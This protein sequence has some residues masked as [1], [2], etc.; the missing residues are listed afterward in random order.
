MNAD[1]ELKMLPEIYLSMVAKY[2]HKD[3]IHCQREDKNLWMF[4]AELDSDFVDLII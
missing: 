4:F 3:S 1:F 2:Y